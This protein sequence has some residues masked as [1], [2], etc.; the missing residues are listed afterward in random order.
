MTQIYHRNLS[1]LTD[2]TY[3]TSPKAQL[4]NNKYLKNIYPI[5]PQSNQESD[6][7]QTN[8][9]VISTTATLINESMGVLVTK[10]LLFPNIITFHF[11]APN[12]IY[13][14]RVIK[15]GRL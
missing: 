5:T 7:L 6:N 4:Y 13:L 2:I 8:N 3:S 10:P 14:K 12:H 9:K 15:V 11:G 1:F